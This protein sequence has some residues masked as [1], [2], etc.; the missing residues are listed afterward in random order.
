M[1]GVVHRDNFG[2]VA[3]NDKGVDS[4]IAHGM[5]R[6]KAIA[7]ASVPAVI[8]KGRQIDFV[9]NWKGR[10]YDSYVFAAPIQIGAQKAFVGVVVT[11]SETDNRYYL[12]EVSD[13]EGNII[14]IKKDDAS[15]KSKSKADNDNSLLGETSSTQTL[16]AKCR[17]GYNRQLPLASLSASI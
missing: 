5:G 3:I 12:H 17:Y 4:S 6:A 2:D 14:I 13:N 7:F 11:K 8:E 10:N 16:V 1:D 9:K 15:F